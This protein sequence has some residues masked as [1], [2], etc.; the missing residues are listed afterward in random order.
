MLVREEL[1]KDLGLLCLACVISIQ[2]L[3]HVLLAARMVLIGS[4]VGIELLSDLPILLLLLCLLNEW[5]LEELWPGEPLTWS[6]VQEA[7]EEGFELR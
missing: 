5:V 1:I 2:N 6:L 4:P 7:L 3:L